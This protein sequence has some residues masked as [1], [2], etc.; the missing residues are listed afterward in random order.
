MYEAS[1]R[2]LFSLKAT[3]RPLIYS[4]SPANFGTAIYG[5]PV[6]PG[7][8]VQKNPQLS[9]STTAFL[10]VVYIIR[11]KT[12][13]KFRVSQSDKRAKIPMADTNVTKWAVLIGVDYYISGSV[14]SNI[15]FHNLKGCVEDVNQVEGYLRSSLCVQDPYIYR[16][17]A[18]APDDNREEPIEPRSQWPNYENI[19]HV[20]QEVTQKAKPNDLIYVHYS[21]HG[22]RVGTIFSGWKNN[23][24]DEALVPTDIACGGRYIRDVEIAYLLKK[25]TDKNLVVTLVLDCCHSGGANRGHSH[26]AV[27]SIEKIDMNKLESDRSVFSEEQLQIA[28]NRPARGDERAVKVE[29][30]WLLETRGYAFLAACR[31]TEYA[32]EIQFGNNVQGVLTHFLIDTL[33]ASSQ[34][35]TYRT[36][37]D[38]IAPKVRE[39]SKDQNVILGGEGDRLF[40]TGDRLELFYVATLTEVR[41]TE[42]KTLVRLNAG[43]AHGIL[44][45]VGF[46]VWPMSCSDFRDSERIAQIRVTKVGDII[47]DAEV[48]VWHN[49]SGHKL[50]PGCQAKPDTMPLQREVQFD[51]LGLPTADPRSEDALIKAKDAIN[52]RGIH[53]NLLAIGSTKPRFRVQV[54]EGSYVLL[55]SEDQPLRNVVPPLPF[56][57]GGGA[58]KLVRRLTHLVKYYNVLELGG[59]KAHTSWLSISLGKKPYA[60]PPKPRLAKDPPGDFPTDSWYRA[61]DGDWALL[62]VKN[63][64]KGILNIV[65]MDLD[66]SW[67]IEQIYPSGPGATFETLE[68]DQTLYLPLRVTVPEDLV[69]SGVLDTI[70]VIATVKPTS[71]RWL[72]LPDLDQ[73]KPNRDGH[74]KPGNALEALQ[75]A[76]MFPEMRKVSPAIPVGW[77]SVQVEL[78]TSMDG[79]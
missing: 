70:K 16:L 17:T 40:F 11:L 4:D 23:N 49:A 54:K 75:A 6:G 56:N 20:L 8:T 74:G 19:I 79:E 43:E 12:H 50:E 67:A 14:R 63:K 22:A 26:R 25:M 38:L 59:Q 58:E 62:R 31:S 66:S 61:T 10:V 48:V 39:Y 64:T 51:H 1:P 73:E 30:H 42:G 5:I 18:T 77:S 57:L 46:D 71:F 7:E 52:D 34:V 72:E 13:P 27:R 65:V 68:S 76:M 41:E 37:W 28:W 53:S 69:P 36:L 45:D 47:A 24:L 44:R 29:N 32:C 9:L 60:F 21:G 55:G 35:L 3:I 33:K 15:H 2:S 78:R